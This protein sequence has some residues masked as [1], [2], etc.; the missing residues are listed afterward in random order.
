VIGGGMTAVY[1]IIQATE[2]NYNHVILQEEANFLLRKIN[3]AISGSSITIP[4]STVPY[5]DT[6]LIV[7]GD[8][9]YS[10]CLIGTDL[11]VKPN[12]N[13]TTC[14]TSSPILNTSSVKISLTPSRHLFERLIVSG[15]PDAVVTNFT[16]TTAQNGRPASQAFS[17]IKYLRK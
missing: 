2:A 15:K 12:S 5:S 6:D 13:A 10:L 7:T 3:W 8:E 4:S 17:F 16:L 14:S 11:F 1:Q 9:V